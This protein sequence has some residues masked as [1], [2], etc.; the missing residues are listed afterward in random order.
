MN[1]TEGAEV[2]AFGRQD[3]QS[4]IEP[5]DTAQEAVSDDVRAEAAQAEAAAAA[6]AAQ[7]APT[8][9]FL[10]YVVPRRAAATYVDE[11]GQRRQI[12]TRPSEAHEHASTAPESSYASRV[13]VGN[14]RA[15]IRSATWAQLLG[16]E[17]DT[18]VW[19]F[20]NNW[21]VPASQLSADQINYLLVDDRQYN[22]VRFELVDGNG[23]KVDA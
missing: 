19:D 10:E 16:G 5:A 7:N 2:M 3:S 14:A 13:G 1:Q 4:P 12:V 22:G 15:V 18:V 23:N 21:R 9:R 11:R 20:A 8:A 6:E 17:Y